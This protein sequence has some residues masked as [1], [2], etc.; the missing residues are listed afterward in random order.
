MKK[1]IAYLK[2]KKTKKTGIW[3]Q[4]HKI[5][6]TICNHTHTQKYSNIISTHEHHLHTWGKKNHYPVSLVNTLRKISTI[7]FLLGIFVFFI[8][9]KIVKKKKKKQLS[10][11]Q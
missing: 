3:R 7:S 11:E 2:K 6:E 10:T 9:N 5:T 1:Q 8:F 4:V